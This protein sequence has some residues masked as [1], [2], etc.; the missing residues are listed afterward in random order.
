MDKISSD[1]YVIDELID[2]KKDQRSGITLLVR[3]PQKV[4]KEIQEFLNQLRAIEPDQ[5]YYPDT[6]MHI[7]I[8][9][10]ISCYDGFDID[11]IDIAEYID[12]VTQCLSEAQNIRIEFRGL[13]ASD[14]CIMLQ[15][16]MNNDGLNEIRDKL[17]KAFK[18]SNLEQS[19]DKRYAIQTAHSTVVRFRKPLKKKEEFLKK[20]NDFVD[21]GFGIFDVQVI[22]LVHND[23]YQRKGFVKKLYEFEIC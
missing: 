21:H 12:I 15:G 16:F 7:T 11:K 23:W 18:S 1:Q 8:M 3:P 6:D 13:T 19:L 4:K 5:Y 10:I 20:V 17:R 22:E 9:S 14:S 2:S